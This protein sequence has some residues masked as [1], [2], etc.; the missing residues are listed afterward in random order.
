MSL[1]WAQS[2]FVGFVTRRLISALKVQVHEQIFFAKDCMP[3]NRLC[4]ICSCHRSIFR[5]CM[6]LNNGLPLTRRRV[7]RYKSVTLKYV[8]HE[9]AGYIKFSVFA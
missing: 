3:C 1:R 5:W 7:L 8:D 4:R 9:N 6:S 2:H